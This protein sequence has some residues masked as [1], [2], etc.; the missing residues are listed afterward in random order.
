MDT[1]YNRPEVTDARSLNRLARRRKWDVWC[2]A[3]CRFVVDKLND[4]NALWHS[5][6]GPS[7]IP[8]R[9]EMTARVLQP[10]LSMIV[11]H[12]RISEPDGTRRYRVRLTGED[13][14]FVAGS[15]SNKFYE[16]FLPAESIPRWNALTDAVLG[17]GAPVRNVVRADE[18]GRPFLVGEHFGAP[19]LADDGTASIVLSASFFDSNW[20]FEKLVA[21]KEKYHPQLLEPVV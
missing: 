14:T 4:L 6:A 5:K 17:Q 3:D 1:K 9:R 19:L 11:L 2:D 7:G 10:Y 21:G 13:H 12:E 8:L 15:V 18:V 20:S 16:E